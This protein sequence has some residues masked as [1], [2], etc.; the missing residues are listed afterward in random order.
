[1]P[2]SKKDFSLILPCYNESEHLETSFANLFNTLSK[3]KYSFEIILIDDLSKD[4]TINILKNISRK[5]KKQHVHVYYHRQNLGRGGTVMDGIKKANSDIV[6]FIDIDLE[7]SP[8]Y[9][10]EFI[11]KIK[12]NQADVITARRYYPFKIFPLNYLL[13]EIASRSYVRL[14]KSLLSVPL[15]DTE[16]GYKFFR[17]EKILPILADINDHHWFW[18]TE[19]I[20]RSYL[21]GLRVADIP[22]LFLRRDDKT[23]TVKFLP[24]VIAYLK[25]ISKFNK[26]INQKNYSPPG[27]LYKFP[28]LYTFLMKI[29][30]GNNYQSRYQQIAK[31]ITNN[32]T[33]IDVCC[34][35]AE[36][37]KYLK[38]K[39]I[40]Y[41][42]LDINYQFIKKLM[43]KNIS[44]R[45]VNIENVNDLPQADFVII[46]GSLYQFKKPEKI[47]NK[48][49]KSTKKGL[50]ISESIN[51][52]KHGL[53]GKTIFK[54]LIPYFVGTHHEDPHFRFNKDNFINLLRKYRPKYYKI[55]GGRD[56][57]AYIKK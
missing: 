45:W 5:Y 28:S 13:R 47:I 9:I 1:M 46:Q 56:L 3:Q 7:V 42:G 41:L 25:A 2:R 14:I 57:I 49:L 38:S 31:L 8:I 10:S 6:G 23:S 55:R 30:Y 53:V 37:Y 29:L 18:D 26:S 33:V 16:A 4:S 50:I 20:T 40:N 27:I 36:L 34:G 12:E 24:D 21:A 19:I 17:K 52:L 51:N 39:N 43:S 15:D 22:T 44:C 35:D 48:L 32:S 54:F 11:T